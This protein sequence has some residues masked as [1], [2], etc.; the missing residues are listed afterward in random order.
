LL[1]RHQRFST[2]QMRYVKEVGDVMEYALPFVH[3]GRLIFH[4]AGQDQPVVVDNVLNID[5][6]MKRLDD[7]VGQ[8]RVRQTN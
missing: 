3:S 5:K 1:E 8:L 6:V 7:M 2:M 4:F